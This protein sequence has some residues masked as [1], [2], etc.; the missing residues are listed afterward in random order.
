MYA[1]M[2]WRPLPLPVG[3]LMARWQ[4]PRPPPRSS[5][6]PDPAH[7][8]NVAEIARLNGILVDMVGSPSQDAHFGMSVPS[9]QYL[10]SSLSPALEPIIVGSMGGITPT[11]EPG[12]M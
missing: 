2:H 8:L 7:A 6:E 3:I 10:R 4:C 9:P 11:Q 12:A 1:P 5:S